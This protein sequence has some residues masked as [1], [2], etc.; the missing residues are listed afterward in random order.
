M[1]G[2]MIFSGDVFLSKEETMNT[3]LA[4]AVDWRNLRR[5]CMN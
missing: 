4:A 3:P 5:E 2:G 1:R